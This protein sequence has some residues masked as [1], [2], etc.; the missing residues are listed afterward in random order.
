MI[1]RRLKLARAAAGLSL[2]ALAGAISHR[3]TAQAIGKY[4]RDEAMPG[5]AVLIALADALRTTVDY[6]LGDPE[7]VLHDLE[8]RKNTFTSKRDEAQVEATVLSHLERYLAIEDILRLPSARWDAPRDAPY[9]VLRDV[10]EADRAADALRRHWGL[11]YEPIPNLVELLE[12]AA[13]RSSH[14]RLGASLA[15]PHAPAT[16]VMRPFLSSWSM[17]TT[18][19]SGNDSRSATNSAHCA[20]H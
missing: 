20:R 8:F 5:S 7:L 2:R 12:D 17:P 1:G 13:S 15:S 4:E 9:P 18:G 19:A 16:W 10:V 11:G 3:V 6:L 14:V